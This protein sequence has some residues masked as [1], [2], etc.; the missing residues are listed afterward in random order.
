MTDVAR[1]WWFLGV[2]LAIPALALPTLARHASLA[3]KLWERP[4]IHRGHLASDEQRNF[5]ALAGRPGLRERV[6]AAGP[7][8]RSPVANA[9]RW[10]VSTSR[11]LPPDSRIYL[12]VPNAMLYYYGTF[13]WFPRRVSVSPEPVII[14]DSP[15]LLVGAVRFDAGDRARLRQFGYTHLVDSIGRRMTVINLAREDPGS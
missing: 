8:G 5:L 1:R 14:A 9:W 10:A 2:V 13:F 11:H 12:N 3:R 4:L 6:D 15:T 7:D